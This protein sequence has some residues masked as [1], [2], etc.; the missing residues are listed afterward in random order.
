MGTTGCQVTKFTSGQEILIPAA[1]AEGPFPG[2]RLVTFE[3]IRGSVSGF[4]A[5]AV[6][7]Q[8]G[9][10]DYLRANV[11]EVTSDALVVWVK[12]SFFN[13]NGLA[14]LPIEAGLAA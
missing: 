6:V 9:G 4:V 13:T 10:R 2:E 3:T 8:R 11:Q 12:G 5:E 14:R 7:V 1:V